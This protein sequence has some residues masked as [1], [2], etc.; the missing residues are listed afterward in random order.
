MTIYYYEKQQD[1]S[2]FLIRVRC[3]IRLKLESPNCTPLPLRSG[4]ICPVYNDIN[5]NDIIFFLIYQILLLLLT[6]TYFNF[7]QNGSSTFKKHV[8]HCI[9]CQGTGL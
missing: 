4:S 8:F 5:N 1:L 9:T 2:F 6:F 7:T 3:V